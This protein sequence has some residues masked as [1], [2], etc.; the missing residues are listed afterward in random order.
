MA[1]G[2]R[3]IAV[4][5]VGRSDFSIL[6]PLCELLNDAPDFDLTLWVGGGHF[7]PAGGMTIRDVEASGLPIG[8]RV[9]APP[10]DHS[11]EGTSA[12]MAGQLAGFGQAAAQAIAQGRRPDLVLILGDRFEA[13]AAGAAMVPFG[14]PIAHASG[15]SITEG[16]I[17]DMFRHALTKLAALHICD[18]PE[19]A[20]RI[21]QMGEEPWRILNTGALGL[22]GIHLRPPQPLAAMADHFGMEGLRP[23][24]ILATLHP[25]TV[26]PEAT[27]GMTDAMIAALAGSGRQV[28]YTYP[29]AD[30]GADTIITAIEADAAAHAGHFATRNFGSGWFYTA[31]AHAGMVVGNSSSGI[32]EAASFALP[33]VN[34]GDRQRGRLHG[35]NVIHARAART[36][37]TRA[38]DKAARIAPD[39]RPQDNIYGDGKASQRVM[40]ALRRMDWTRLKSAKRFVSF[41]PGYRGERANLT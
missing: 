29:N 19:F 1:E 11:A 31:M 28:I 5:T 33:V 35:G 2:T 7:D 41:D 16:A 6:R 20:Q 37:I 25:E 38:M 36:D 15:G 30:P 21:H 34:I 32:Y 17:D 39:L 22:D 26:A 24:Y 14:L 8:A 4:I 18:V 12:S 40:T 13:I 23:G 9:E 3:K 27:P 10:P